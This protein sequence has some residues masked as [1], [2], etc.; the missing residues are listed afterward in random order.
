[1]STT[2][3]N[4]AAPANA[5]SLVGFIIGIA[6]AIAVLL[7]PYWLLTDALGAAALILGIIGLSIA[8]RTGVGKGFAIASIFLGLTPLIPLLLVLTTRLDYY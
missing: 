6:T 5:A 2:P 3:S 7:R 1:M 8:S 4:T